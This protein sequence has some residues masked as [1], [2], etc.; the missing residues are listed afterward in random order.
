M[1]TT[2][3]GGFPLFAGKPICRRL[4]TG[5]VWAGALPSRSPSGMSDAIAPA[6]S[7]EA[8]G[9]LIVSRTT[10]Q[11]SPAQTDPR[12]GSTL[13]R[14]SVQ[15]L[16]VGGC[17]RQKECICR[18]AFSGALGARTLVRLGCETKRE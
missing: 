9:R 12:R 4:A 13:S 7:E 8:D 18:P 1:Q 2:T 14:R 15:R 5:E 10:D 6:Q 11:P 3:R 16:H 17:S